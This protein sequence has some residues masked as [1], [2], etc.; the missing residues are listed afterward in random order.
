MTMA[1]VFVGGVFL[2]VLVVMGL[3]HWASR[4]VNVLPW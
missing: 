3:L 4:N 2:G 1:L